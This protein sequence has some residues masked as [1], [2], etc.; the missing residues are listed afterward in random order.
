LWIGKGGGGEGGGKGLVPK[1][2]PTVFFVANFE[3]IWFR[4]LYLFKPNEKVNHTFSRK[5]H[6]AAQ[7]TENYDTYADMK[8]KTS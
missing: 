3:F 5:I 8:N 7:N 6:C 1:V 4:G 2:I